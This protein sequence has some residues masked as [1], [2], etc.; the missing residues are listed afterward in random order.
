MGEYWGER[1]DDDIRDIMRQDLSFL[2]QEIE[3]MTGPGS[4][5]L[6]LAWESFREKVLSE[7]EEEFPEDLTELYIKYI[8]WRNL[9]LNQL[10]DL[11]V[12]DIPI[13]FVF[14]GDERRGD[15]YT[16]QVGLL[17]M[18]DQNDFTVGQL[19][20]MKEK[21]FNNSIISDGWM[22]VDNSLIRVALN[23]VFSMRHISPIEESL[24]RDD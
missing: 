17:N 21:E 5:G 16:L 22:R 18:F 19:R 1:D 14:E 13:C 4:K 8:Q 24:K 9:P 6:K 7:D 15:N 11:S 23:R 12:R 2:S 10:D 20:E 3:R